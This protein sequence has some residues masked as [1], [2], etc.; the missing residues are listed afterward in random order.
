MPR[1]NLARRISHRPSWYHVEDDRWTVISQARHDFGARA[2]LL[3]NR[4]HFFG[5]YN[6]FAAFEISRDHVAFDLLSEEWILYEFMPTRWHS[7][8]AVV[9]EDRA[10]ILGGYIE[11]PG[12]TERVFV[13]EE[14]SKN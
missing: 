9:I 5:G 12:A 14:A 11:P 2:V 3:D 7:G 1:V 4:L 10:W 6:P 13:F 8:A